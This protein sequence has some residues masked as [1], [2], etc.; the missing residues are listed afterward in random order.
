MITA[1]EAL[2]NV[3]EYITNKEKEKEQWETTVDENRVRELS[4][5]I[6]HISKH[7][8]ILYRTYNAGDS[9]LSPATI[10]YLQQQGYVL[11]YV[12]GNERDVI[13]VWD[14]RNLTKIAETNNYEIQWI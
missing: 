4:A 2:Q 14:K 13:I 8:S 1:Q 10:T 7:G 6:E 3:K 9:K 5:V 12:D 11:G